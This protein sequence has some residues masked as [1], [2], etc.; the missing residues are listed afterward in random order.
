MSGERVEIYA[1]RVKHGFIAVACIYVAYLG[2]HVWLQPGDT[3][4][5]GIA[6]MLTGGICGAGMLWMGFSMTPVLVIDAAGIYCRRPNFGLL[7]WSAIQG[8]GLGRVTCIIEDIQVEKPYKIP[9]EE[10]L[11][12]VF[13]LLKHE[14]WI[15]GGSSAIN[16]AGAIR[17]ARDMGPGH[18]IVTILC[19]YGTRYQSKLFNPAFLRSKNLPVPDWLQ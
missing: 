14:G 10:A 5:L 7:P 16:V 18:T 17:L 19:D 8:I 13:D 15:L 6:M 9:D 11:P 2:W 3:A 4:T 1:S 12:G